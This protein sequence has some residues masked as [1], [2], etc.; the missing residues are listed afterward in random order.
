MAA[1]GTSS[2]ALD[3]L[4][5]VRL[6]RDGKV[7]GRYDTKAEHLSKLQ[8]CLNNVWEDVSKED[9]A[10]ICD[11]KLQQEIERKEMA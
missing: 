9:F 10:L 6:F 3:H 5:S 2:Q 1:G 8:S 11:E 4:L 7:T